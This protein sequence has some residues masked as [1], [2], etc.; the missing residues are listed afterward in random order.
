MVILYC[1]QLQLRKSSIEEGKDFDLYRQFSIATS[2]Y[3]LHDC[4]FHSHVRWNSLLYTVAM[5]PSLL[6]EELL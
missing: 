4:V 3:K 2:Q 6:T 1:A 5:A